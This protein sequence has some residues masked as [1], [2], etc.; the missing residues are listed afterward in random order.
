MEMCID[1][2]REGFSNL[3]NTHPSVDARVKAL[4]MLGGHDPGP[5]PAQADAPLKLDIEP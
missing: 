1:N 4:V 3:F 2:P 5:A